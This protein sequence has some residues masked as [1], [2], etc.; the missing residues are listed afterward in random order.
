M[1][2]DSLPPADEPVVLRAWQMLRRRRLIASVVFLT[3]VA[4][5]VGFALYLPDLYQASALVLIERQ[6]SEAVARPSANGE[7]ENRLQ[8]IKQEIL[9]RQRL[10]ELIEKFNL[11]QSMRAKSSMETA[12]DQ[13]RRDIQIETAGPEQVNGRTKTVAFRLTYTGENRDSV[14]EVTNALANFYV[15]QNDRMRSEEATRTAAFLNGRLI[16]A[17]KDL[18]AHEDK[19]R[20]FTAQHTVE[21]PTQTG[22]TLA[23][24]TRLN[25]QLRLNGEQ[26]LNVME[27]RQR[28]LEGVTLEIEGQT[29]TAVAPVLSNDPAEIKKRIDRTK[30]E[31]QQLELRA[32]AKH[33]DVI[34]LKDQLAALEREAAAREEEERKAAA[35]AP[36]VPEP[37]KDL[38]PARRRAL[39][40]LDAELLRLKQTEADVR[41]QIAS[42]EHRLEGV[43]GLQQE[44]GMLNRDQQSAKE[45]Y[46]SLLKRYDE[47]QL[48]ASIE[49]DRQGERFRVL[50]SAIPPEG[51]K[52]PNRLRLLLMGLLFATAAAAAA[53]LVAEQMDSSFHSLDELRKF[54]RI[55]VLAAIPAI[56]NTSGRRHAYMAAAVVSA[57]VIIGLAGA[58]SA[59]FA[60]GNET[61]VRFLARTSS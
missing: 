23:S 22:V 39:E 24:I 16:D 34:R 1:S 21:M 18:D 54:T 4:S 55:P 61:L 32:S 43:P 53:I 41:T 7:L 17:K 49:T 3:L 56:D 13:T 29:V 8:V 5:A 44:F 6:V 57:L 40:H 52:A 38:P 59:H 27:Q 2:F 30:D 60:N 46:D 11:Y 51:P 31:L 12:L 26:Q 19:V 14:A 48:V 9:S 25:D 36:V 20:A 47:A 15:A 42:F 35:S 45:Q 37:S 33:P 50:E 58:A 10:T 28:L